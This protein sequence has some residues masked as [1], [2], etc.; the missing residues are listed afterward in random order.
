MVDALAR[1]MN[2]GRFRR[3]LAVADK[4]LEQGGWSPAELAAIYLVSCRCR[5]ATQDAYGAVVSGSA[6]VNL[7]RQAQDYDVL[8]RARFLLGTAYAGIGQYDKALTHLYAFFDDIERY[9][10]SR[11]LEGAV[12]KHIGVAHQRR[13]QSEAAVN[14][15]NQVRAWFSRS[16][17][18]YS[19]F[20]C[21]HDLINT[22]LQLSETDTESR[23]EDVRALLDEQ[24]TIVKRHPHEGYFTGTYLLDLAAFFRQEGR[25][26][27]ASV[28]AARALELYQGDRVHAFHCHLL[29][30]RCDLELGN[31]RRALGH[32]L[33]ARVQALNGH[34]P[35][36]ERLASQAMAEVID[37]VG[38]EILRQLNAEY[39][40]MGVDLGEYLGSR[41]P[42]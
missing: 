22:Y 32:A 8:G 37:R 27:R 34:L 4:M 33:A 29:L 42:H 38:P 7:A 30:H 41:V 5:L 18:D 14:A 36:L 17:I 28:A 2:E 11:R 25:V 23:V 12:W 1:L 39:Q 40:A 16:G 20:T 6:A 24:R 26:D 31:G 9:H 3:C 21:N 13:L 19:A 15:F 35:D 10:N